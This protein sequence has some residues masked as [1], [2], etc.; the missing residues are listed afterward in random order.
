MNEYRRVQAITSQLLTNLSH[1]LKQK[2]RA[3]QF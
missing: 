2:Q 3:Q 1:N